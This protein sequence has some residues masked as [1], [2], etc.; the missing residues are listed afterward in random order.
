MTE[1]ITENAHQLCDNSVMRTHR[2]HVGSFTRSVVLEVARRDGTLAKARI[3]VVESLVA[4]SPAQFAALE[5]RKYDLVFTSPDNVL[6]YRFIASNPL[7]RHLRV[8]MI[9]ALDRGLGLSLWL[10]PTLESIDQ[11]RGAALG[12][13]VATSGLAFAG[14]ELLARRGLARDDYETLT[15]G[16]TL[17][18]AEAL[19]RATCAATLLNAGYELRA[20]AAGCRRVGTMQDI[21]PFLGTVIAALETE[22][23]CVLDT[24]ARFVDVM[25][26][27]SARIVAGERCE[28]V[29]AAAKELLGLDDEQAREHLACMR[30]LA[31]GLT[32]S[33]AI[34][35]ASLDVVIDLRRRHQPSRELATIGELLDTVLV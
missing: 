29:I 26:A 13:D 32:P 11:V 27:T 17:A 24:R 1:P 14:Y 35:Q 25:L 21:G 8:Q 10:N 30:D 15:L 33:G 34:D 31:S 19:A 6:A 3:Q 28:L 4:T 5:A 18:R 16:S 23:R 9:A 20:R 7:R 12:V 2:L 22:D